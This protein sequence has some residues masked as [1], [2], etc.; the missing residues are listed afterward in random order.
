LLVALYLAIKG[1]FIPVGIY[2]VYLGLAFLLALFKTNIVSAFMVI[3]TILIQFF[4]YGWG[5]LKSTLMLGISKKTPQ[6]I[7]PN[8]FFDL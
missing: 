1:Q 3:P 5:F 7:F 4:G 8:L 6:E 2:A